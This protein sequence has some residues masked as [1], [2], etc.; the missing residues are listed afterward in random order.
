MRG[1]MH[2][3]FDCI[4]SIVDF[5]DTLRPTDNFFDRFLL[6]LGTRYPP[7]MELACDLLD[8]VSSTLTFPD[9]FLPL[10][11]V[12]GFSPDTTCTVTAADEA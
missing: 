8:F 2:C 3:L 11:P 10:P 6:I 12:L 1:V 5:F 9:C 4:P 7:A